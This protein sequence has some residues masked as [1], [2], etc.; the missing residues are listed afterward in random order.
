MVRLGRGRRRRWTR[1][2]L[3]VGW[4]A[5]Q[6][7]P[8]RTQPPL[9]PVAHRHPHHPATYAPLPYPPTHARPPATHPTHLVD[10]AVRVTGALEVAH[11]LAPPVGEVLLADPLTFGEPHIGPNPPLEG[12]DRS[13][14]VGSAGGVPPLAVDSVA[15][16]DDRVLLTLG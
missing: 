1:V 9:Q 5:R 7:T 4:G 6:Q 13:D 2:G 10:V 12:N 14:G 16:L 3:L 15:S 11:K 8:S